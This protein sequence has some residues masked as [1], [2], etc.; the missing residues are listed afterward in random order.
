M[1]A[2]MYVC[3]YV[4]KADIIRATGR[5]RGI[6]ICRN[7]RTVVCK[8]KFIQYFNRTPTCNKT[9][10]IFFNIWYF[11]FFFFFAR[12]TCNY[13]TQKH[14]LLERGISAILWIMRQTIL[15]KV[16]IF[17]IFKTQNEHVQYTYVY[18]YRIMCVSDFLS[19]SW[20]LSLSSLF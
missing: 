17:K 15:T 11:I 10:Q 8:L 20:S 9:R 7:L 1:Y 4:Y 16:R 5:L 14:R 3:M 13:K 6:E 18:L 12:S 2:R 19:L